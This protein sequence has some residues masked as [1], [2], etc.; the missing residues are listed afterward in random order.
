MASLRTPFASYNARMS[1][2]A[3]SWAGTGARVAA[4]AD[5]GVQCAS[6]GVRSVSRGASSATPHREKA[7][8][9]RFFRQ[10]WRGKWWRQ[11][12]KRR[13]RRFRTVGAI[14]KATAMTLF[15]PATSREASKQAQTASPQTRKAARERLFGVHAA[16][17]APRGCQAGVGVVRSTDGVLLKRPDSSRRS[18]SSP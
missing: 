11:R 7:L 15:S 13:H 17:N 16:R 18:A 10:R 5:V 14:R 12:G 6:R 9:W 4:V 8:R 2:D 3:S 1:R